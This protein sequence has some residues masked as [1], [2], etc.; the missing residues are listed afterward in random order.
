MVLTLMLM[1]EQM[2]LAGSRLDSTPYVA[3]GVMSGAEAWRMAG[4]ELPVN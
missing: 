3:C 4:W 2:L 1:Y